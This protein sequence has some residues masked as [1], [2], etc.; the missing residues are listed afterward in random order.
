MAGFGCTLLLAGL[1][2]LGW[3]RHGK[4]P[5]DLSFLHLDWIWRTDLP[6]W[7]AHIFNLTLVATG[8]DLMACG[9]VMILR[10]HLLQR[11]CD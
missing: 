5:Y 7:S 10:A 2:S 11:A 6:Y 8:I 1:F 9:V 3:L 4:S